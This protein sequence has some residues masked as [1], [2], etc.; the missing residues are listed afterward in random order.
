MPVQTLSLHKRRLFSLLF[1]LLMA[2]ASFAQQHNPLQ[3]GLNKP[4]DFK[5]VTVTYIISA[6][7]AAIATAKTELETVYNVPA[8]KR[9]FANTMLALDDLNDKL[10]SVILPINIL[11]NASTDSAIRKQAQRSLETVSKFSNALAVDEKLYNAYKSYAATADAQKLSGGR[12][13]ELQETIEG[14]ERNGF[15]LSAEK[16]KQL[17]VIN[18][19][20]SELG[21]AFN[22]N[23]AA[24]KDQLLVD[25]ADMKGLP[26]DYVKTR[27]KQGDKYIITLDGP[28]YGDFMKYAQSEP[29]RKELY[30]KYNNR[31]ADKNL[32]ILK[33]LLIER[34]NKAKLLGFPS[35]AAYQT[36]SRMVKDPATVWDFENKLVAKVQEKTRKDLEELL[37]EKRKYLGDQSVATIE[38]WEASFYNNL[39]MINKYSVDQEQVKEYLQLDNV[40]D[41]LFKV[42][43]Q[44]FGIKYV[45]A[46]DASI[47]HK[48]V[49]TFDVQQNG[50]NIGRFYL[51]LFPRENKYT[52][53]ACFP[54]RKGKQYGK[55][56]Q[57]PVAAL[58]CNFNSP[59][60][61]KPSLLTHGQAVT[62]FHEFG[63]VLHNMLTKA[64]LA[65]QSGT[66][67][68]RDFVEA[69]SQIF[70][71]WVW[72]YDALKLF[73]KHYKTGEVLPFDLYQK[74]AAARNVGSGLAASAQINYGIL[75]MTLHDQF[76]A[77]GAKTTTD[78]VKEVFNKIMPYKHLDG[79]NMQAAFGHLNGYGAG[80]YSYMWSKVYAEDM[81]SIF[82]KNGLL[83]QKTG[84]RY[85]NAVLANG[86]SKD[87]FEMVKDFLG[88]EPDQ[89]AFFRSLGL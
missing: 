18:D 35:Y 42:T 28:S 30:V 39:L 8:D 88:R 44:L 64:E 24:Y 57:L 72:N 55:Q 11:S 56:Y 37:Q 61:D 31:A 46:K 89:A 10:T 70:E 33:Q 45:E 79:T 81:F 78:V 58:I 53:A 6:T 82:E 74:I 52:H 15:A 2:S 65:S 63:H 14:F 16:R 59:T 22:N 38:P 5:A 23:I 3:N 77:S 7:D 32:E 25:E 40:M 47:W 26:A 12:K 75:D 68:K 20:I 13:K 85:R 87:E 1:C 80:Y 50:V 21:L 83:D 29:R 41:G 27:K 86:G 34:Q 9:T 49:R 60:A 36:A 4:I 66:S 48:D 84:M 43:Q 62:F 67:V 71:N 73:A 54:I 17:Q 19:K 76:D 69:P 51:D